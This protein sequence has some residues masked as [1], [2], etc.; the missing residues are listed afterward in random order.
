MW[1]KKS[2]DNKIEMLLFS[3]PEHIYSE[4][5]NSL[6]LRNVCFTDFYSI[7]S[8]ETESMLEKLEKYL[9]TVPQKSIII[10]NCLSTLSLSIGIPKTV[11]FVEKLKEKVGQLIGIYRRDFGKLNVPRIETFGTTYLKLEHHFK[12]TLSRNFAYKVIYTHRKPGGSI[13][14]QSELV[15]QDV[16]TYEITSTEILSD[17]SSKSIKISQ[18]TPKKVEASFRIEMNDH[19]IEQRKNTPLPYTAAKNSEKGVIFYEPEDVDDDEEEDLDDDLC[20]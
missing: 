19:E 10:I 16:R 1:E 18:E 17:S 5:F 9:Q 11:W 4:H 2:T 14:H 20:I 12:T 8:N 6:K 13:L 15:T 3:S 7:E